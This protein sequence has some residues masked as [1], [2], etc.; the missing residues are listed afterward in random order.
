MSDSDGLPPDPF[1]DGRLH[2]E[3]VPGQ[4]DQLLRQQLGDKRYEELMRRTKKLETYTDSIYAARSVKHAI[5]V[6]L[7]AWVFLVVLAVSVP[8][9]IFVWQ[10]AF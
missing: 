1:T 3:G 5:F 9:V 6:L 8:F 10:L 7:L 2:P 4:Q